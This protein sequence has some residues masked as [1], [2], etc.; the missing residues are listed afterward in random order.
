MLVSPYKLSA[1]RGIVKAME[2][3][4]ASEPELRLGSVKLQLGERYCGVRL[5]LQYNPTD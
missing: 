5:K 1:P 2:A 3:E 4:P